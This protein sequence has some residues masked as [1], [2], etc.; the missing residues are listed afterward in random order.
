MTTSDSTLSDGAAAFHRTDFPGGSVRSRLVGL[1]TR[2]TARPL[3]S[4]W[5]RYPDLRWPYRSFDRIGAILP[6]PPGITRSDVT[7]PHCVAELTTPPNPDPER[8]ILYL[9]GGGFL[10]GGR[11]LHRQMIGRHA[12]GLRSRVL[13]VN[14]RKMPEY[15]IPQAISDCVDGYLHLLEQG[16]RPDRITFMGDSAGGYLVLMTAIE[17]RRRNLPMPAAIV[18]ISPLTDLDLSAKLEAPSADTCAM[19]PK[20]FLPAIRDVAHRAAGAHELESPARVDPTGLPP[21]LIH[22][23]S[24]EILYPDAISMAEHLGRHGVDCE[25]HVWPDQ[26]HVFH[27]AFTIAPEAAAAMTEIRSF[28]ES[29]LGRPGR[30]RTA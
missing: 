12:T 20:P 6:T 7:L 22:A 2:A 23:S 16:V 11:Y 8:F 28:V 26:I 25:L 10:I 4:V 1:F 19:F 9:H 13:A 3:I 24:S 29:V 18:S 21:T 15:G 27:A 17:L 5:S 30:K 14:Y